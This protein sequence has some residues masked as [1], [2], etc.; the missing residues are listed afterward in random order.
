MELNGLGKL[1]FSGLFSIVLEFFGSI[2]L[3]LKDVFVIENRSYIFLRVFLLV[4]F[5]LMLIFIKLEG[6]NEK[7]IC[8]DVFNSFYSLSFSMFILFG[9][10][11]NS[12]LSLKLVELDKEKVSC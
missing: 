7:G 11:F 3:L 6:F 2:D 10:C 12:M 4:L 8:L 1:E 9:S 5:V